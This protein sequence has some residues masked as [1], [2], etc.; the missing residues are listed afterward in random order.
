ME[1]V[2]LFIIVIVSMGVQIHAFGKL[3]EIKKNKEDSHE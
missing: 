2:L 1:F 3:E